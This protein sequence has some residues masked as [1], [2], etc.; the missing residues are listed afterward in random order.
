MAFW[1]LIDT[2]ILNFNIFFLKIVNVNFLNLYI[3]IIQ[4]V[5]LAFKYRKT[6]T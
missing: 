6:H 5:F 3:W 4:C 2:E 1:V